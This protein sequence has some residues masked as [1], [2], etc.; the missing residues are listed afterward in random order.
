MRPSRNRFYGHPQLIAFIERLAARVRETTGYPG[1]LI[2]DMA[3]PRGGPMLGGH[4]S[5]QAGIDADVW[6]RPMPD[7]RMS[8][9]ER[10]F[11][12]STM[13]VRADRTD[14]DPRAFTHETIGLIRAAAVDPEVQRIFVNAAIKKAL[15][16]DVRGDRTWLER[17]VRCT[18]TTTISTSGCSARRASRTAY[19]RPKCRAATAATP[20]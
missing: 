12:D 11:S 9:E 3:Q 5:H 6:L 20:R 15:C 4:A 2:G 16:R 19:P 1:I 13:M 8:Q 14:V 7:H 10:E 18:G 17:C